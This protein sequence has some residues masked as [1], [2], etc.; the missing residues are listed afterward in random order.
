MRDLGRRQQSAP[1]SERSKR[2]IAAAVLVGGL[3]LLPSSVSAQRADRPGCD[4]R[5]WRAAIREGNRAQAE[6]QLR[7]AVY[8][9]TRAMGIAERTCPEDHPLL[10]RSWTTLAVAYRQLGEP[11]RALGLQERT[12]ALRE[13][14]GAPH[15]IEHAEVLFETALTCDSLGDFHR[16]RDLHQQALGLRETLLN[17]DSRDIDSSRQALAEL[18]ERLGLDHLALPLYASLLSSRQRTLGKRNAKTLD[19]TRRLAN[20]YRRLGQHTQALTHFES[21]L[22]LRTRASTFDVDLVNDLL[23]V[24][25]VREELGHLEHAIDLRERALSLREQMLAPG[26]PLLALDL[27]ALAVLHWRVRRSDQS[28]GL[29]ARA[30]ASLEEM[31][32]DRGPAFYAFLMVAM[33]CAI[34]GQSETALDLLERAEASLEEL[35]HDSRHA[36]LVHSM[37]RVYGILDR[38]E[39]ALTLH[40]RA[41]ALRQRVLPPDHPSLADSF[42]EVGRAYRKLGLHE[43]ALPLHQQA[44]SIREQVLPPDHPDVADSLDELGDAYRDLLQPELA[45]PFHERSHTLRQQSG[46]PMLEAGSL[47][48]LAQ[49]YL[50]LGEAERAAPIYER[51]LSL[52]EPN[53]PPDHPDLPAY[54]DGLARAHMA[55]GHPDLALPLAERVLAISERA[56]AHDHTNVAIALE[57]LASI[58]RV[59]GAPERA[60]PL[61]ER[62]ALVVRR[63]TSERAHYLAFTRRV[64]GLA[65]TY[66]PASPLAAN[67]VLDIGT[68]LENERLR[69]RFIADRPELAP[70]QDRLSELRQTY[71]RLLRER[72]DEDT[73]EWAER[74]HTLATDLERNERLLRVDLEENRGVESL[75]SLASR[76]QRSL[77]QDA[78]LVTIVPTPPASGDAQEMWTYTALVVTRA[79]GATFVPLGSREELDSL[80]AS[81]RD[82]LDGLRVGQVGHYRRQGEALFDALFAPLERALGRRTMLYIVPEGPFDVIPVVALAKDGEYLL[83]RGYRAAYLGGAAELLRI[84]RHPHSDEL[85][86][87][88]VLAP[89]VGDIPHVLSA[90]GEEATAIASLLGAS[91]RVGPSR[92]SSEVLRTARRPHILHVATHGEFEEAPRLHRDEAFVPSASRSSLLF[93]SVRRGL[94][95]QDRVSAYEIS[96]L[97]LHGTQLVVLSACNSA[98]GAP[99]TGQSAHGLRRAFLIAGAE[100]VVAAMWRVDDGSTETFMRDYYTRLLQQNQPRLDALHDTMRAMKRCNPN[101]RYWAPFVLLGETGPLNL[102][103]TSRATP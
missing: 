6:E 57:S 58:L 17:A 23:N 100:T 99:E 48:R 15:D 90:S 70:L 52:I 53:L 47:L 56:F 96:Q 82:T 27:G 41:L 16:S 18:Y 35:P 9:F 33:H 91:P 63:K 54:L 24:A 10:G 87:A 5:A 30:R 38:D 61:Y 39:R 44:L 32:P 74:L 55:L 92:A 36:G 13:R 2:G 98:Q 8:A 95:H 62:A 50:H 65:S 40:E 71:A 31:S 59:L 21:V 80:S 89:F 51:S 88:L 29:L 75:D 93:P 81:Y 72:P 25:R 1:D 69:S 97:D 12:L 45:L 64:V 14:L 19:T 67:L 83:D 46:S 42:D 94:G 11:A 85:A 77:A 4:L 78:A 60:L 7:A 73:Q 26:D 3:V 76:I 49:T 102:P 22:V 68:S 103:P 84:R 101:P 34:L 20:T 79:T 66:P 86:P 43:L 28:S 37:G